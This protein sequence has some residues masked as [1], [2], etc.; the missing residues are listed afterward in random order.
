MCEGR[1]QAI[2]V[3]DGVGGAFRP[4]QGTRAVMALERIGGQKE[5]WLLRVLAA[6][7]DNANLSRAAKAALDKLG[8]LGRLPSRAGGLA[9]KPGA[10][11]AG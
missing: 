10:P 7:A 3:V 8:S 11:D 1:T 6:D 2:E 9:T 5:A 4:G